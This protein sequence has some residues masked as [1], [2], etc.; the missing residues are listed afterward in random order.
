LLVISRLFRANLTSRATPL[1]RERESVKEF[2][3]RG[4]SNVHLGNRFDVTTD[5]AKAG[6]MSFKRRPVNRRAI[7]IYNY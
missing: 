6:V 1:L 7:F 4:M 5:T 2:L 3:E